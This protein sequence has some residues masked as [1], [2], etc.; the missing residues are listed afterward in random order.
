MWHLNLSDLFRR[1]S[2]SDGTAR[3]P[4]KSK[5]ASVDGMGLKGR[6]TDRLTDRLKGRLRT[7]SGLL[8]HR[9]RSPCCQL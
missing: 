9:P 7:V 3:H 5:V 8:L 6:L 2:L 1:A 4:T